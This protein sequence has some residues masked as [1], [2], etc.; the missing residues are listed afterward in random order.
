MQEHP[1]LLRRVAVGADA[2]SSAEPMPPKVFISYSHDS[3][4]HAQR[5]LAL[6]DAL[7]EDEIE[8]V[9]DQYDQAPKEGWPLWMEHNLDAADFVLMVCTETYHRRVMRREAPGRGLGVQWE[10]NLIY[11][12]IYG[13]PSQGSRYIPILFHP[14]DAC[15]IPTPVQGHM[16]YYLQAFDKRLID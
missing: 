4:E 1:G 8:V 2:M 11:N 14:S 13:N 7:R 12:H 3:D 9:L 16:H 15:Y 6:A 10:G 5:V